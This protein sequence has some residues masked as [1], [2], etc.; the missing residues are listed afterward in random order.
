M[1]AAVFV[2]LLVY[3]YHQISFNAS[4]NKEFSIFQPFLRTVMEIV[5][6]EDEIYSRQGPCA[7]I[8]YSSRCCMLSDR[9][10]R[11]E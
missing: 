2:S 9:I 6:D 4:P 8:V 10:G 11:A 3:C 1:I 7:G 5:K